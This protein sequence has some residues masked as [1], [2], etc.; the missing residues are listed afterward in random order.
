[1]NAPSKMWKRLLLAIALLLI[2]GGIIKIAAVGLVGRTSAPPFEFVDDYLEVFR[3]VTAICLLTASIL[4]FINRNRAAFLLTWIPILFFVRWL[5]A[6]YRFWRTSQG[7]EF[8]D[9]YPSTN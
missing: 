5:L 7:M 6:Y 1:M 3:I 4:V 8:F 9:T 2:L